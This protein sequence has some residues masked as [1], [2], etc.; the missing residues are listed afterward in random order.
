M[1]NSNR[2]IFGKTGIVDEKIL[3]HEINVKNFQLRDVENIDIG[4]KIS[5]WKVAVKNSVGR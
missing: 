3:D 4:E 5:N 2:K 1:K